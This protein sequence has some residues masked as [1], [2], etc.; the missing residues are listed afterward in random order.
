[1]RTASADLA[2]G[3]EYLIPK[4]FDPRLIVRIAPAVAKAA[5]ASGVATRPIAD[6]DAYRGQLQQ[7]VY[8]SGTF[9]KPIF[10]ARE[11]MR[12]AAS[13]RIVFAE[14]EDE[15]V[16]RAAQVVI[17]EG[18]AQPILV[19]RPAVL[20]RR[21]RAIRPAHEARHGFRRSSI[22]ST[23]RAIASTGRRITSSPRARAC[24]SSTPRSRCA[25]GTR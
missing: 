12:P 15:R 2:F 19:G 3:P 24:P 11:G 18:I 25:V 14:G 13:A 22:R 16:L 6:F 8:H 4:P 23:M 10:A 1:M 5:M 9:M 21:H 20:E 17:D 7:F